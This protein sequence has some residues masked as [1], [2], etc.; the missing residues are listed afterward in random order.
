[1]RVLNKVV[2]ML[3]GTSHIGIRFPKANGKPGFENK[4]ILVV[5]DA[6]WARE[7]EVFT[8]GGVLI[9]I[10]DDECSNTKPV[11][12]ALIHWQS[13]RL[14]RVVRS[15]L[16]GET[17]TTVD[18]IDLAIFVAK[19]VYDVWGAVLPIDIRGDCKSL[20]EIVTTCHAPAEKRVH[21]DVA[22]IR[23]DLRT[24][25]LRSAAHVPAWWNLADGLTKAQKVPTIDNLREYVN[26]GFIQNL[27]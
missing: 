22:S 8:Q 11:S 9:F 19:F 16:A 27:G 2:R 20:I 4:R 23:E 21:V 17:I 5:T 13:H 18:G 10:C 14:R 6:S 3:K 24:G 25:I 12:S 26:R 7:T 15:T 1:M